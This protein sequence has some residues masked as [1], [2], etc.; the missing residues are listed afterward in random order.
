MLCKKEQLLFCLEIQQ[1]FHYLGACPLSI[2]GAL[3]GQSS[4]PSTDSDS[5]S[6]LK[7]ELMVLPC[8]VGARDTFY[9]RSVHGG[10]VQEGACGEHGRCDLLRERHIPAAGVP[11]GSVCGGLWGL[12]NHLWGVDCHGLRHH[13]HPL[14]LQRVAAGPAGLEEF[15]PSQRCREQDKISARGHKGAAGAAQ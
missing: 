5:S 15:P 10:G 14:L 12:R 4:M 2:L 7:A 3:C 6:E 1:Q 9:L 8:V 13:L 11:G